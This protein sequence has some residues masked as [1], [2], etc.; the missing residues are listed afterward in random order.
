MS[1]KENQLNVDTRWFAI[2]EW[3]KA[4]VIALILKQLPGKINPADALTKPL[5][6]ILHE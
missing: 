4:G 6:R 1:T 2:Q 3:Q 5:R